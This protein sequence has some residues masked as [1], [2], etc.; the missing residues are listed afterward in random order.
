VAAGHRAGGQTWSWRYIYYNTRLHGIGTRNEY[1]L[2]HV[3]E[4]M[5]DLG[6]MAGDLVEFTR[7]ED[8]EV[9]VRLVTQADFW[10]EAPRRVINLSGPA[11]W[12]VGDLPVR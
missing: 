10:K 11:W 1:R 3:L 6:A 7:P 5:R 9:H 8:G 4:A 12:F 2:T